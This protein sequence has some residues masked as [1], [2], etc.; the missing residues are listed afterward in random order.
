MKLIFQFI[1]NGVSAALHLAGAPVHLYC[2]RPGETWLINVAVALDEF[3][4]ALTGG[5]P[6]E[7]ISSRA[8][9]ARL[10]G[11]RWGCILCRILNWFQA[12]H[13]GLS[14]EVNEGAKAVI[15]DGD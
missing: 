14:L 5:D 12:N 8:D 10:A 15:P 6:G 11:R 13:C 7:T 3:G 1:V 2:P 9:K 4:N